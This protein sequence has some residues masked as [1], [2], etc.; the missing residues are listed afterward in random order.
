MYS[1]P[2]FV[3]HLMMHIQACTYVKML[4]KP[5]YGLGFTKNWLKT[6]Q[7]GKKWPNFAKN[8]QKLPVTQNGQD[9]FF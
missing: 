5:F 9:G 4:K 1:S 8:S 2:F 6:G 3:L 7:K